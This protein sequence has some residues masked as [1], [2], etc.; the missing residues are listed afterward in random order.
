MGNRP[1][2]SLTQKLTLYLLKRPAPEGG[3]QK[4]LKTVLER[5]R[6]RRR[7][8]RRH[9]RQMFGQKST[10]FTEFQVLLGRCRWDDPIMMLLGLSWGLQRNRLRSSARSMI[11]D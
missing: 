5:P 2:G 10:V 1:G 7:C 3:L 6:D 11:H 8:W 9:Y 4:W